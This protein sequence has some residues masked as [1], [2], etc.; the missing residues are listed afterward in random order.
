MTYQIIDNFLNQEDFIKIKNSILN[1]E[2]SW[3][4]TPS[5]SN[6]DEKLKDTNIFI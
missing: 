1:P 4:L 5:V 3:N 2:F 6:L